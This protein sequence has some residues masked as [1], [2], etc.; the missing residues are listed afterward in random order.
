MSGKANP[1]VNEEAL[2]G[3]MQEEMLEKSDPEMSASEGEIVGRG[4]ARVTA[5][6]RRSALTT[7]GVSRIMRYQ[8]FLLDPGWGWGRG[9]RVRGLVGCLTLEGPFSAVSKPLFA[10]K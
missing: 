7:D 5:D 6:V 1:K 10:T 4:K 2:A 3:L 9:Q 8:G